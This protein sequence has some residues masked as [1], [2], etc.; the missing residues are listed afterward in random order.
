MI[1]LGLVTNMI[2]TKSLRTLGDYFSN[3]GRIVKLSRFD[4][5]SKHEGIDY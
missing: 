3:E 5:R 2:V 1:K 4:G